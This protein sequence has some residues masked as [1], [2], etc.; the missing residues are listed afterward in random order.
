MKTI[1]VGAGFIG[2]NLAKQ[3]INEGKDVILIEK[4]S[5]RA[6]QAANQLDCLVLNRDV[7]DLATL[8]EANIYNADFFICVTSSDEVNIVTCNIVAQE[9]NKICKIARI[10]NISYLNYKYTKKSFPWI[11]YI[12]NSKAEVASVIINTILHGATSELFFFQNHNV[13]TLTVLVD[14][15]SYFNNKSLKEIKQGLAE[16]FIIPALF[17]D[18]QI[19]VPFGDIKIKEKDH[20]YVVATKHTSDKIRQKIGKHTME[21]K[22]ILIVGAGQIG[23]FILK[24]LLAKDKKVKIIEKN[25]EKCKMVSDQFPEAIV[26]HGDISDEALYDEEHL[27]QSDSIITCTSSQELNILSAIYAKHQ[28]IKHAIALVSNSHFSIMAPT[29][30]IDSTVNLKKASVNRILTYMRQGNVKNIYSIFDGNAEVMESTIINNKNI[31]GIPLKHIKLPKD[32]IIVAVNRNNKDIIPNGNFVIQ[33]GDHIITL[34]K[35]KAIPQIE[36]LFAA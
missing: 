32:A 14:Q 23:C 11:D 34:A 3:L 5:S 7:N 4:D 6:K 35:K 13:Y 28:G 27:G 20:I 16:E 19:I 30:G 1:I 17:R 22:R 2:F 12:I 10:R 33:S 9:N 29:L 21:L 25:Y 31:C 15:K 18:K 26:I 24:E 8:K 36:K